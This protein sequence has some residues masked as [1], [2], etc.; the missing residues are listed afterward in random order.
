MDTSSEEEGACN[1]P[2]DEVREIKRAMV[3]YS[4]IFN[5]IG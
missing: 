5:D 3:S 1:L 4:A 2:Q